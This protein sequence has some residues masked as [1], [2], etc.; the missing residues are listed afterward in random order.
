VTRLAL[1]GSNGQLGSDIVRLWPESPL[2][3]R[4]LELVSLTH[5]DLEVADGSAVRSVLTGIGPEVVVNTSAFHRVDDCETRIMEAFRVNA[6][7][8]KHL[9]EVCR[10]LDA[11]LVHFSTDYV[12]DGAS[13]R[14]Y[15]ET[16]LPNPISAYGVSKAAGEHILRYLLPD[17]HVLVRSSGLYGVAGASGKGGNFAE[18]MLRLVRQGQ[19]IRV[20]EDQVSA[21]TSTQDLAEALFE[22]LAAGLR[23]TV[24]ITNAGECS[25]Y[26]FAAAVFEFAGVKPQFSPVSS[27]EFGSPAKRPAYSVLA[28]DRLNAAGIPQPRHWRQAL[29]AYMQA[30]GHIPG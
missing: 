2:A 16:D 25:W 11:T 23:G 15:R 8:V 13:R 3:S 14:P 19:P 1:I 24:H 12:F 27:A 20:V 29:A 17:D 26:E 4:G 5:A 30:K 7:G 28:N 6:L 18:T 9:A 10:D 22:V 21:P